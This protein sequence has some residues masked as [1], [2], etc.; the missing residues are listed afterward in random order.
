MA[1]LIPLEIL[2]AILVLM[3]W[4]F[5]FVG[6]NPFFR[7]IE[8]LLVGLAMGFTFYTGA[9]VIYRSVISPLMLNFDL[10]SLGGLIMGLLL[11]TRLSREFSYWARIPS[12]WLMGVGAAVAL[13]AIPKSQI[14]AQLQVGSFVDPNI[15][16]SLSNIVFAVGL[17]TTIFYFI[18]IRTDIGSQGFV[19]KLGRIFLMVNF[20][21]VLGT[22][23]TTRIAF[24][25]GGIIPLTA[26]YS[27]QIVTA[28][29]IILS[30]I[31]ILWQHQTKAK[32]T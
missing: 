13:V 1:E 7:L 11:W 5:L 26:T 22:S 3:T 32:T 6:E 28:V 27:G 12:S 20:G 15:F 8:N 10:I 19:S 16:Q 4:S 30:G 31:Y 9:T 18:F 23:M 25:L 29:A 21:A 14:L 17:F 2:Q 24:S